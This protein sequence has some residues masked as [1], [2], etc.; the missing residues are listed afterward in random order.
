VLGDNALT[1]WQAQTAHKGPGLA[2]ARTILDIGLGIGNDADFQ[3]LVPPLRAALAQLSGQQIELGATRKI[4]QELKLLP[5]DHQIGQTG[6]AVAPELLLALGISGAPQHM[7]WIDPRAVVIA[8]NRDAS[9]PIFSWH[10]Q[11]AGPQ[12]IACIGDL[13]SWLPELVHLLSVDPQAQSAETIK[14]ASPYYGMGR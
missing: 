1:R 14:T 12:V 9:A 6:I 4:T 11:N 8:I 2:T 13:N 3:R 5:L 10:K 7:S